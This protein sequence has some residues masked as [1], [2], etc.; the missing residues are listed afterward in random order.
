MQTPVADLRWECLRKWVPYLRYRAGPNLY[1]LK[2]SKIG[3]SW[4]LRLSQSRPIIAKIQP[5]IEWTS[6]CVP[7]LDGYYAHP[8][9]M[10]DYLGSNIL[11]PV[12]YPRFRLSLELPTMEYALTF[13]P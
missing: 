3:C 12:S 13:L 5:R 2:Y 11:R 8:K 4:T 9:R 6:R 10:N 7:L 1:N